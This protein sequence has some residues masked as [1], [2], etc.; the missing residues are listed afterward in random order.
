MRSQQGLID[1]A[2]IFSALAHNNYYDALAGD[3]GGVNYLV[4]LLSYTAGRASSNYKNI[5][6]CFEA[7]LEAKY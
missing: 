7:L 5:W 6:G 1:M 4:D 3:A 2:A